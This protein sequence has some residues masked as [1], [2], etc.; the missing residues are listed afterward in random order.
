MIGGGHL[1]QVI[2]DLEA[3]GLEVGLGIDIFLGREVAVS[4][5]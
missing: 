4:A 3:S 2:N 1:A 5:S